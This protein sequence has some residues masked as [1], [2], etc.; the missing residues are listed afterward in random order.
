MSYDFTA[1][2][3]SCS[4]PQ[5]LVLKMWMIGDWSPRTQLHTGHELHASAY[6]R[7]LAC[8]L[9]YPLHQ[10]HGVRVIE[11]SQVFHFLLNSMQVILYYN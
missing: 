8:M 3:L 2:H 5:P 11:L 1:N 9:L 4:V 7:R 10:V 6:G